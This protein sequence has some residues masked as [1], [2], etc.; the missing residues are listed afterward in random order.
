M[1]S[2]PQGRRIRS[3]EKLASSP[4]FSSGMYSFGADAMSAQYTAN[5]TPPRAMVCVP[6]PAAGFAACTSAQVLGTD[7]SADAGAAT[8]AA[9]S[10]LSNTASPDRRIGGRVLHEKFQGDA[11]FMRDLS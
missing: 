3:Y 9:A 4:V 8:A 2:R 10:K 7:T 1:R 6:S 11:S 5:A